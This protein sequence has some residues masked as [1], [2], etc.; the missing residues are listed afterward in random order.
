MPWSDAGRGGPP[1]AKRRSSLKLD[2]SQAE[3]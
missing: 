3:S 1:V 2:G